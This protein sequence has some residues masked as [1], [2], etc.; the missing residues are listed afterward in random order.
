MNL[1]I[2]TPAISRVGNGGWPPPIAVSRAKRRLQM[3]PINHA[4]ELHDRVLKIEDPIQTRPEKIGL[5]GSA[6]LLRPHLSPPAKRRK[7]GITLRGYCKISA[8]KP[9]KTGKRSA[10]DR[11]YW[12]NQTWGYG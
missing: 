9:R 3:R 8:G 12:L 7:H 11:E 1:R 4:R 10:A 6:H 2:A 5:P